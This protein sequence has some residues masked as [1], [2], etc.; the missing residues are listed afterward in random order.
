MLVNEEKKEGSFVLTIGAGQMPNIVKDKSD[1]L[2]LCY[3]TSDSIMY[4]F[5]SDQGKSFSPPIV[6]AVLPGLD[7][8]Y[9]RGPQIAATDHGLTVIACDGS[10]DIFSYNKNG[11]DKWLLTS[12]VNDVDTI[13]KE[14]FMA[15]SG[16]GENLF[17]VWLDLRRDKRNNLYGSRSYDGGKS[18]SKNV[19]V[20]ASP[21]GKVCECCKPSVVV[22]GSNVFVMFR[23]SLNGN[24]DLYLSQSSDRGTNF[25]QAQKLGYGSWA[26]DGCPMDGGG[27]AVSTNNHPQTVW[28][29]KG[30]IFVCEPGTQEVSI[31]KG[32][33]C[34]IE[35]VNDKNIYAWTEKD[36]VVCLMP[37]GKKK[38]LGKGEIPIIKAVNNEHI[39]C[40]W[41][42]EKQ[43][44]AAIVEL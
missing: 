44:Q 17:A 12:K 14:G 24:R 15:L 38:F 23:N 33:S 11:S 43:I 37:K 27:I 42:N 36:E 8:A 22:K 16:D 9:M 2:H 20:Y 34:T 5:S 35:S 3:G 30:E 28:F 26:L 18:W 6:I 21:D 39:I 41:E 32:R 25:G 40:V 10:G 1:N 29:R 19:L 7:A 13:A 31:G 4:S